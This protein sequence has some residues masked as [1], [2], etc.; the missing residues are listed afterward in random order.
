MKTHKKPKNIKLLILDVDGVLT[1]G[2][3]YISDTGI[4]SKSFHVQDGLGLKLLLDNA[5]DVAVISG[6]KSNATKKRLRDLGIKHA[7]Y[8]VEDKTK[9]FNGLKKKLRI[10]NENIACMGDDL[11]DLPIMQQVGFSIAVA[12]AV[13]KIRKA[14]NYITK[15]KGGDGAV[16]E[17]CDLILNSK[18]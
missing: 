5:V 10:K 13:S 9:P 7:Y 2:K 3:L 8:G 1:D 17:A 18:N 16:R 14:A 6:R 15:N 11:P 4:E 12:N